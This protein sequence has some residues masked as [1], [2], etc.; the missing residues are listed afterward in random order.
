MYSVFVVDDEQLVLDGIRN[1]LEAE[2]SNFIFVGEATD[3]ELALSQIQEI[4]PDIL[5]TDIKMPFMDGLQLS[6]RLKKIQ[7]WLRII[8]LSGHDEFSYAKEAISIGVED[9]I[10]KPF[11]YKDL[12]VSLNKVSEELDFE[13]KRY[14]DINKMK[15]ELESSSILLRNQFLTDVMLGNLQTDS[16][17]HRADELSLQMLSRYYKVIL[18]SI[19]QAEQSPSEIEQVKSRIISL[20]QKTDFAV[21]FFIGPQRAV[22]LVMGNA[23]KDIDESCYNL[24]EAFEHI[25]TKNSKCNIISAIGKTVEH[26]A[27]ISDSYSEAENILLQSKFWNMS[28][29]VS[30]DDIKKSSDGELSLR[31]N[32]PLVERLKY[33]GNNEID[34]IIEQY[35]ESLKDNPNHFSII[36]SY[37]LVDVI[38]AVSKL[39]EDLG[40]NVKEV[41]PEILSHSFVDNAVQN[42]KTFIQEIRKVLEKVMDYRDQRIQGR[43][44]EVILKAKDY[45]EKN[46]AS[47]D[48]SLRLVADEVHLSPNHFSTIFS[49]ECGITFIEYLTNKRIEAAKKLLRETD[50]KGADIAFECGFSDPH[51]FSFIFKKNTGLSPREYRNS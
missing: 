29:I 41:M 40:G 7:P 35:M 37:L 2:D 27:L 48:T 34:Q 23:E 47:Q 8:I 38:M 9:Y 45:I 50:M 25:V 32:D 30:A 4:K 16:I 33:A 6:R 17:M 1:K 36:A 43:Y 20:A 15:E 22:T 24:A 11:T 5:I 26:V 3:G 10:L 14:S 39:I 28:R 46:Y 49:Q 18:S 31:E 19:T 12:M 21:S 44:G 42:E 13:H 51:Y